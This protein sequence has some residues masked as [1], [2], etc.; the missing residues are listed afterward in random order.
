MARKRLLL[1]LAKLLV[2]AAWADGELNNDEINNL[3]DLLFRLPDLSA[4]DWAELEIYMDSPVDEAERGRVLEESKAQLRSR[5]DQN[6]AIRALQQLVE[7]DGVVTPEEQEVLD[8]ATQ[9]I[10]GASVGLVGWLGHLLQGPMDRRA[11]AVSQP[12]NRED[13]L[14]DF[15]RNKIF[16]RLR[17]R[18]EDLEDIFKLPEAEIRKLSLAG[19]L[20]ARV[21]HVDQG[22]AKAER[23][24]I[25]DALQVTWGL[26][27]QAAL[28]VTNVAA[29]EIPK[30]LDDFRLRREFF[31][32]TTPK[33]R[34]EFLEA[35]FTVAAADGELSNEEV[36]EIRSIAH[37]LKLTHREFIR[38]KVR[39]KP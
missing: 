35:L 12:V 3:K 24:V 26:S 18:G 30:S 31:S 37:A 39:S 14:D 6:L 29:S 20:L 25:A 8:E 16:Y 17:R 32:A 34:R 4:S 36:E 21:A 23:Q 5:K 10:Q 9:A 13:Q 38:A 22:I 33:E 2:A 11:K 1:T 7:A 15:V 28:L 27:Q 19:G